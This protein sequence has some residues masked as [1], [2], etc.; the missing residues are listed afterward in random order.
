V[1]FI[2][3][4]ILGGFKLAI[5]IPTIKQVCQVEE[6]TQRADGR[7]EKTGEIH[8]RVFTEDGGLQGR[9][10]DVEESVEDVVSLAETGRKAAEPVL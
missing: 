4:T 5:N 10:W 9:Y 8:T 3:L 6:T 1:K 2:H 7:A